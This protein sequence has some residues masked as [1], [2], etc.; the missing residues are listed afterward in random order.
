MKQI[1]QPST[2]AAIKTSSRP[3][4]FLTHQVKPKSQFQNPIIS[5]NWGRRRSGSRR[6]RKLILHSIAF[7]ASNLK[8]LP[9]PWD[10]LAREF[11]VAAAGGGGNG[12]KFWLRKGFG[13]GGEG[14]NR[15]GVKLGFWVPLMISSAVAL[16]VV[17]ERERGREGDL[18]FWVLLIVS[19]FAVYCM[20]RA[21]EQAISS[22]FKES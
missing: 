10:S 19:T 16:W 12:G 3:L 5:A 21:L 2:M 1:A 22:V 20:T 9:E 8:I 17:L 11:L 14:R 13:G 6:S 18:Y 4:I 7:V 15:K